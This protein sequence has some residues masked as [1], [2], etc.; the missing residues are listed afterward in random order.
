MT[1]PRPLMDVCGSYYYGVLPLE[2][3][4]HLEV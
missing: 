1:A 3:R 4:V 2:D